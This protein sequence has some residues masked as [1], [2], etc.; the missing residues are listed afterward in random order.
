MEKPIGTVVQVKRTSQAG[1]NTTLGRTKD[2]H[3]VTINLHIHTRDASYV[4]QD[5]IVYSGPDQDMAERLEV[6][7]LA[8]VSGEKA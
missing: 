1:T 8:N 7:L 4:S 5:I 6:D 3:R 2:S